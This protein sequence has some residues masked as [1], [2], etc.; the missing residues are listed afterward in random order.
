MSLSAAGTLRN[1]SL[2]TC[3]RPDVSQHSHV[4]CIN[5]ARR[6]VFKSLKLCRCIHSE[7]ERLGGYGGDWTFFKGAN[8]S[9]G[10][11]E[12]QFRAFRCFCY[13]GKMLL[14]CAHI[15]DSMPCLHSWSM[16]EGML[17]AAGLERK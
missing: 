14:P 6:V 13:T 8:A 7:D 3:K 4:L 12:K 17:L 5:P 2:R 15:A 11:V 10:Q 9:P 16:W 1:L